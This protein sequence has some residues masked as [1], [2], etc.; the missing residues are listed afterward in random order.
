MCVADSATLPLKNFIGVPAELQ[1]VTD[2]GRL[3]RLCG[4]VTSD[5]RQG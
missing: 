5:S 3:R 4:I 1:I 2:R